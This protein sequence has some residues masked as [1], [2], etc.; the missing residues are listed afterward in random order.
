MLGE[1][2]PELLSAVV[3]A[4]PDGLA[5]VSTKRSETPGL[6]SLLQRFTS[7]DSRRAMGAAAEL[8][9][10]LGRGLR[11][12]N[13]QKTQLA[14]IAHGT[15]EP[16]PNR[17]RTRPRPRSLEAQVESGRPVPEGALLA[18]PGSRASGTLQRKSDED[19]SITIEEV[20]SLRVAA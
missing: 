17:T 19:E 11:S 1:I 9:E 16:Q 10:S 4:L 18:T 6:L 14:C 15:A 20:G 3:R 8:L 13:P 5:Q 7:K 2:E 12:D